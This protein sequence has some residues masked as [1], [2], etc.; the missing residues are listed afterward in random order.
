MFMEARMMLGSARVIVHV[1]APVMAKRWSRSEELSERSGI[2]DL[3]W[4]YFTLVI[5]LR[6]GAVD[7]AG[8]FEKNATPW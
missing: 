5:L 1:M 4:N 8:D 7:N 6:T 3:Q 2:Y